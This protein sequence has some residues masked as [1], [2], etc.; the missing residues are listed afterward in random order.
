MTTTTQTLVASLTADERYLLNHD[1]VAAVGALDMAD[2]AMV[3]RLASK[4]LASRQA[5]ETGKAAYTARLK[6]KQAGKLALATGR[7]GR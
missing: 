5:A 7:A 4:H 6:A 1:I 2:D 3:Q